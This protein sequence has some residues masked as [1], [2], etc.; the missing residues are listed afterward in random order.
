[1]L[2]DKW[3]ASGRQDAYS[4]VIVLSATAMLPFMLVLG[5]TSNPLV[6]ISML[7][8]ATFFSA[9]QGGIA[10]GVIQLMTP[11]QM[12]GQVV[13]LYFL[14]ANLVGLGLGP[15]VIAATTDYVFANDAAIGQS[16]AL[17]AAVLC[18]LAIAI[19]GLG[20]PHVRAAIEQASQWD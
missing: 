10:G 1:M 4:R 9:F 13:A 3:Y 11:N 14:V 16:L 6:G 7:A 12:R 17:S 8:V 19:I 2:A 15:T 18:P 20:M 5:F